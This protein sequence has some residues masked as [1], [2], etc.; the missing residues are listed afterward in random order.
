M[1]LKRSYDTPIV[2]SSVG[3][4]RHALKFYALLGLKCAF[5]SYIYGK[6]G[7]PRQKTRFIW[8]TER[9]CKKT[10]TF[11]R[12]RFWLPGVSFA[13]F[14]PFLAVFFAVF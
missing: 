8:R 6:N 14:L 11:W 5:S 9:F 10:V 7:T 4:K 2:A 12:G 1:I 13:V 3:K